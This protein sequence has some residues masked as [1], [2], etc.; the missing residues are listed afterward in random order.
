MFQRTGGCP[1]PPR[2]TFPSLPSDDTSGQ[3]CQATPMHLGITRFLPALS[4]SNVVPN[5]TGELDAR[6]LPEPS[7]GPTCCILYPVGIWRTLGEQTAF[8]S[9]HLRRVTDLPEQRPVG[10][11]CCVYF[12]RRHWLGLEKVLQSPHAKAWSPACGVTE[13]G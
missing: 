4:A 7:L 3:H 5:A 11:S 10:C 9:H 12:N 1:R 13:I 6:D 2:L 8:I